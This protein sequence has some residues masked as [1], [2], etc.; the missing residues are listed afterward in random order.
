[1]NAASGFAGRLLDLQTNGTS[2]MVVQGDGKL[3]VG[4]TTTVLRG[5]AKHIVQGDISFG[6]GLQGRAHTIYKETTNLAD[7]GT[8][9]VDLISSTGAVCGFGTVFYQVGVNAQIQTFSFAGRQS[10]AVVQ[11]QDAI[12]RGSG[13]SGVTVTFA[14]VSNLGK[15]R[16]TNSSGSTLDRLQVTLFLHSTL[17]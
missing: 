2:Q 12:V 17:S 11:L 6:D 7:A 13:V 9:D 16:I 14:A 15:I 1:V 10:G 4:S 3:L 5:V 8:F